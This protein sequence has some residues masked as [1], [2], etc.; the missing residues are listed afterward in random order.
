MGFLSFLSPI[1]GG[2]LGAQGSRDASRSQERSAQIA[3]D[4]QRRQFDLT[5]QDNM[6]F[7]QN[8]YD[9]LAQLRDP[10]NN[11]QADPG[12]N[13]LR[14]E[15]Q[16]GIERSAAARGGAFS[17]NALRSLG[18]FN[19]GL[20][21]QTFGDW[22]NRQASRAGMGQTVASNLGSFGAQKSANVGNAL[23][24]GG[25]ARASGIAGQY[26]ALGQ[27][28]AGAMDAWNYGRQQ[29]RTVRQPG[30]GEYY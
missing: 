15:G 18:E 16:R 14:Q 3:A 9:A 19:T 20:A 17:G 29:R 11:F 24:A 12:Y 2:L 28:L 25:D 30:D 23:M 7:L 4:E 13:F 8:G 1:V 26:N 10:L 6:P 27:G 5:R 21:N 22:W